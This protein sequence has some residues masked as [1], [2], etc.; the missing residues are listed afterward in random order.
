MQQFCTVRPRLV[1]AAGKRRAVGKFCNRGK[2]CHGFLPEH[3]PVRNSKP[4]MRAEFR[5][6]VAGH[7]EAHC[8]SDS[9]TAQ[10]PMSRDCLG[11]ANCPGDRAVRSGR[12]RAAYPRKLQ[13]HCGFDAGKPIF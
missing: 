5:L 6:V 2:A 1:D 12:H 13:A 7:A 9:A 10:H 3:Y 8:G 11:K 4:G